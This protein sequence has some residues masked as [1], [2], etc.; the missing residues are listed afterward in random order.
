[1][2]LFAM[3]IHKL[4]NI[5]E[6]SNLISILRATVCQNEAL[7]PSDA[8]WNAL[9]QL[10]R[11]NHLEAILY[12]VAPEA[13]KEEKKTEYFNMLARSV[14][15]ENL[16]QQ[17][18]RVL[19]ENSVFYALQKGSLL[20]YDYPEMTMRFMSDL[21]FYI[22]TEER[23]KV[24]AIIESIGGVAA[25]T[26]SGDDGFVFFNQLGVEFHGRLLY[27]RTDKGIENYPDWSFV[28]ENRNRLTEEGFALNLIGHAVGDLLKGGPG[29]RYILDLWVYRHR[30]SPQPDWTVVFDRLKA[31][32]IDKAAG[33]LLEL[34][35]Y[36]F[37]DGEETPLLKE[38]A[39][40][41]LNGGL[42]GS[43]KRATAT[44]AA[45]TGG[46]SKAVIR[47]LFRS[48]TE[49]ENRY[50]WLKKMPALLPVAWVL[51]LTKTLKIHKGA[52]KNWMFR[53][54]NVDSSD[55]EK[56]KEMLEKFGI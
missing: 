50:P 53:M 22:K 9:W 26:D 41:I 14:R 5:E 39:E 13:L 52:V 25:H 8:D 21:D 6:K 44:E 16:L 12:S 55:V 40:Y 3:E 48:R 32:R 35:E 20:K 28:D 11:S 33:N 30:H 51:R 47:Q 31:D 37:G 23:Q 54:K 19:S 7:I 49:Y 38:M 56:Q 36:L 24:K 2:K 34:S 18:E 46:I 45:K 17:I 10:A 42:Y 29:I 27:R 4:T 1:M 43:S 15:Q